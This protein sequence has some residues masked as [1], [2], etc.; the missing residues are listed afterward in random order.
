[1]RY[2]YLHGLDSSG[3]ARKAQAIRQRVPELETPDFSGSLAERMAQLRS[4][5][6]EERLVLVG[7]SFGGLMA[8]LWTCQYPHQVERQILLAPALHRDDFAP[9]AAVDTPTLLI[10]GRQDDVVPP[11]AVEEKAHRAFSRLTLWPVDDDHR[12]A[13]T[14][15]L[16][17][18]RLLR[19]GWEPESPAS[20]LKP[21]RPKGLSHPKPASP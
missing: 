1:M 17:W 9:I 3:Q 15:Q 4:M 11:Q 10:H 7:S 19:Q 21:D 8:A 12:L 18:P 14:Q 13:T 20:P 5:L 2:L 6:G 16:D